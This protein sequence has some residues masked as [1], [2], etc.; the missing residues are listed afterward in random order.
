MHTSL[1]HTRH[2]LNPHG[3]FPKTVLKFPIQSNYFI[4]I[5]LKIT[6]R[7]TMDL[8]KLLYI[9]MVWILVKHENTNV[10][11]HDINRKYKTK[12]YLA[13]I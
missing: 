6:M 8:K 9:Y 1:R 10:S 12:S 2:A 7:S 13:E 4:N 11:R 5:P 3:V